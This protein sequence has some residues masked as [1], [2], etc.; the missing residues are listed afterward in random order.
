MSFDGLNLPT[1]DATAQGIAADHTTISPQW[2]RRKQTYEE[3]QADF[4]EQIKRGIDLSEAPIFSPPQLRAGMRQGRAAIY[5]RVSTEEQARMGGNEEGYSIPYQKWAC[6]EYA[7]RLGLEVIAVYVDPGKS[8][9]TIQRTD[10]KKMFAEL[11]ELGVTHIIVHKVDRLSRSPKVDYYVDS[12]REKT[13]TALVSVSETIDDSPQGLFNLQMMRAMA[14]YYSNNLATEVKK[15][16]ATKLKQ[17]GTLSQAPLGY[18]NKQRK[19]G[20]A[21]IRWVEVDKVRSPH[22]IWAFEQYATGDWTLSSLCDALEAR[23]LRNRATELRP[24]KPVTPS[25]LQNIFR[26][27]Y[28]IGIIRYNGGYYNGSHPP[29]IERELWLRVQ[30][31]LT[32]HNTAGEK[33][34][35]HPHYLKGSIFCGECGNRLIYTRNRG[36]MGKEYEYYMCLGRRAKVNKCP[37]P[38]VAVKK[39]EAGVEDFYS[40]LQFTP[41]RITAIRTTIKAEL[42]ATR[43]EASE[44]VTFA[45]SSLTKAKDEQTKLLQAHYAGAVP[46]D[47][48]KVEMDRL[49]REISGAETI[50][51]RAK[52]SLAEV[53]DALERAL[54]VAGSCKTEYS[55]AA[56]AIRRLMNQGFF[57][58]LFV[59]RDG[60]I[61]D[62]ELLDPF[63]GLLARDTLVSV[64]QRKA[65][66]KRALEGLGVELAAPASSATEKRRSPSAVLLSFTGAKQQTRPV[67]SLGSSLNKGYLAEGVGFEPTRHFCPLVFKTSSIGRSDS[68]PGHRVYEM[69]ADRPWT[70]APCERGRRTSAALD[71]AETTAVH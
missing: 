61:D 66:A 5:V 62:A 24:E 19:E 40:R 25:G 67:L 2:D 64:A 45:R 10:F 53:E 29:L 36:K 31:M 32:A 16:N 4:V 44:T 39:I 7:K 60:T 43:K 48:L 23:G 52:A 1:Y 42:V 55:D 50:L 28:Y 35:K 17:G 12:Q 49:T 46:L 34:R 59:A 8:G 6:E 56:P 71:I 41:E 21:D 13:K 65:R 22:V 70:A 27:P 14:A 15:G 51:T 18:L 54:H 57:R 26:H 9:T 33:D 20:R 63:S 68:P 30:D 69:Q 3:A 11:S 38:M 58:K 37:L 47:L